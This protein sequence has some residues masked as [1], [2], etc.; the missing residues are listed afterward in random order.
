MV[1]SNAHAIIK[2]LISVYE[3]NFFLFLLI[4][5][6]HTSIQPKG[7]VSSANE[8]HKVTLKDV[9]HQIDEYEF[10]IRSLKYDICF[11]SRFNNKKKQYLPIC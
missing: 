7:I 8:L 6:Q 11:K 2:I 4:Y 5:T 10:Q 3:K 1:N 9:Y